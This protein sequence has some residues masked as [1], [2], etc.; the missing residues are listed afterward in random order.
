MSARIYVLYHGN[1]YDGFGAAWAAWKALGDGA[2][3]I[4]VTHGRPM[5]EME[6]GARVFILDFSYPRADL[7]ALAQR[8][9]SVVVLDH[10][11]TAMEALLGLS[12]PGLKVVFDM[13]K[14]GAILTWQHFFTGPAP[15][16]L[17][18]IQ[19]RDLWR[20]DLYESEEIAA[21]MRSWPFKFN[22][23]ERLQV[24]T[25]ASEGAAI[26]RQ[27]KQ[28]VQM[29]CAQASMGEVGGEA[30]VVVNATA[31]W[32]EVGH[33][34]LSEWPD[35]PFAASWYIDKHGARIWSLRGRGDY[36]VSA[37]AK[38]MGGGGHKDAAGFAES[39]TPPRAPQ[40]K[41]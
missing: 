39:P 7:L 6:N 2:R 34:L 25:L 9:Q 40:E 17:L 16:L 20:F 23:W 29:I 19:D 37:L 22:V 21:A 36:D 41:K 10:H 38:R 33:H 13:D 8:M 5:P 11:K 18:Y 31:F 3:Y 1:C 12:A 27:T 4:P 35:S 26:L 32:S 24:A 14:S 30:C 15:D 28:M